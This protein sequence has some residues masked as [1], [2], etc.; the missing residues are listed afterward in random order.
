MTIKYKTVVWLEG[1]PPQKLD[2]C[3]EQ[4]YK[5]AGYSATVDV[6]RIA[7][8]ALLYYELA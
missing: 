7:H 8:C 2:E 4:G 5:L 3:I 6:D 1:E